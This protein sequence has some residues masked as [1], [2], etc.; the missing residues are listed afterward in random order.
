MSKTELNFLDVFSERLYHSA[1][2]RE[3]RTGFSHDVVYIMERYGINLTAARVLMI[4]DRMVLEAQQQGIKDNR[5]LPYCCASKE[6]IA[7]EL[8]KSLRTIARAIQDLKEAGLIE[9]KR[10][11]TNAML[12]INSDFHGV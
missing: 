11:R 12:F 9:C 8:G 6:W 10:T 2:V 5:G 4:V 3:L 7:N 1:K